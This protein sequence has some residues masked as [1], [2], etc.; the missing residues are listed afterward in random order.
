MT[1]AVPVSPEAAQWLSRF[2]GQRVRL[3]WM[4]NDVV[5]E[6]DPTCAVGHGVSFAGGFGHVRISEASSP[7]SPSGRA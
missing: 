3:V 4:P 7:T 5:R 1:E 6:T 2:L